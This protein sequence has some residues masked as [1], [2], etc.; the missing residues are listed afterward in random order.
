MWHTVPRF[1]CQNQSGNR[2]FSC[3]FF[4]TGCRK[5]ILSTFLIFIIIVVVVIITKFAKNSIEETDKMVKEGGMRIKYK[6]LIDNFIDP[7]SGMKVIEET[8]KYVCVGMT[9]SCG[10]VVFHFQH[11]FN[12]IDVTF[13]MKNIFIGNHK[14]DWSFPET[15]DQDEMIEQIETR[16]R[17]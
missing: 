1:F 8:N 4:G 2:G 3:A 17:G 11:T 9:N 14:L 6:T 10:S 13:E 12:Q 5:D 16:T 15:M 7:S